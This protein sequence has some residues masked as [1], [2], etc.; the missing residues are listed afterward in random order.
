M[1]AAS[2]SWSAAEPAAAPLL[3]MRPAPLPEALAAAPPAPPT[4]GESRACCGSVMVGGGGGGAELL[5]AFFL[6]SGR[7]HGRHWASPR[8]PPHQWP[9]SACLLPQARRSFSAQERDGGN[10]FKS[11]PSSLPQQELAKLS[12]RRILAMQGCEHQRQVP[13]GQACSLACWCFCQPSQDQP[14]WYGDTPHRQKSAS[15]CAHRKRERCICLIASSKKR[16]APR[17]SS[18][19]YEAGS[20]GAT[21]EETSDGVVGREVCTAYTTLHVGHRT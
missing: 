6:H 5:Q 17:G 9:Q 20:I 12:D 14:Q 11:V 10:L 2:P 21:T 13:T 8:T 7:R 15:H 1:P 16:L 3:P 18:F 19:E 4:S